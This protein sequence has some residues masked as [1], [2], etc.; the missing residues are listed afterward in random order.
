MFSS[1]VVRFWSRVI[2]INSLGSHITKHTEA[3]FHRARLIH[4][5][6]VL[7]PLSGWVCK[8]GEQRTIT[9][10]VS[11]YKKD[12]VDRRRWQWALI[13]V[14]HKTSERKFILMMS[15][16]GVGISIWKRKFC[17]RVGGMVS[18]HNSL[19]PGSARRVALKNER[20]TN[21]VGIMWYFLPSYLLYLPLHIRVSTICQ[22]F[23][24]WTD[25]NETCAPKLKTLNIVE[26]VIS[27]QL[28]TLSVVVRHSV[29][30]TVTKIAL[31]EMQIRF[32]L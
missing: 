32:F 22:L 14:S 12:H 15:A 31:I 9:L 10:G 24:C 11:T 27:Q 29:P 21:K 3:A 30:T 8:W 16:I 2:I 5:H 18:C 1:C 13:T 28:Q 7:P 25:A 4:F 23:R 19:G 6:F 20:E 17:Q 26:H